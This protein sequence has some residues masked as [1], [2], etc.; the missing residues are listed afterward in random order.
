MN[1]IFISHGLYPCKIGGI[2]IFNHYL[3]NSLAKFHNILVITFCKNNK[4]AENITK[5]HIKKLILNRFFTPLQDLLN[6]LR[7]K[8]KVDLIH[9]SYSRANWIEWTIF[10]IIKNLFKIPYII[11]IHGGSMH[12]WKPKYIYYL[13]FKHANSIV[14]VSEEIKNEYEKRT[15][16]K[17]ILIPPLIPFKKCRI[18]KGK[19]KKFYNFSEKDI[20][21]LYLGS[22]K[23]IKGT[24]ILLNA[25][26]NLGEKYVEYHRLKLLYVGDG[27]MRESLE[28]KVKR[29]NFKK[30][31]T[32]LGYISHEVIPEIY[33]LSDIY[34]IPSLFE[35]T[36]ISL[37]EAM[38]NGM[39]II[40]SNSR[41]IREII[42]DKKDG[43]LFEANNAESLKK[44]IIYLIENIDLR[45]EIAREAKKTYESNYEYRTVIENYLEIYKSAKKQI[46]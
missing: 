5:L 6:I 27:E 26:I 2:E 29:T 3:M 4:L 9:L 17:I 39:P 21:L 11:T 32:F 25:F 13:F 37:L 28:K 34:I 30:Y 22:I 45:E 23:K 12:R 44:K 40:A 42:T 7:F 20:V 1:I 46:K 8:K 14:G 43:L 41:G 16:K 19:L 24:D 10:P 15:N 35:G 18:E 33:K 36:P 31:I 38:Y